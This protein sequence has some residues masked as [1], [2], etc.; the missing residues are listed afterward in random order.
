MTELIK[1]QIA[2]DLVSHHALGGGSYVFKS[3][4]PAYLK[5]LLSDPEQ[6]TELNIVIQPNCS[7]HIGA[8]CSLGLTFVVTRRMLDIG[9]D[10]SITCD[11]WDRANGGQTTIDGVV[12][13]R[14]LRDVGKFQ[15]FLP[16]YVEILRI[17]GDTYHV[18]YRLRLEEEFL[19]NSEIPGV[20][21][22][23]IL[24]R[25]YYAKYL[26]PEKG[27]LAIRSACPQCGLIEKYGTKNMYAED[28]SSVSFECPIHGRFSYNIH[29]QANQLH[30]NCQLFNLV[31]GL[32]YERVPY[33][34]IE[35]CGGDYAGFWQEQL[36]WR[37]LS[38]PIIIVYTPLISD[39]SSC[40]ISKSMY[41]Q[42]AG[43]DY[44]CRAGQ[45]YLLNYDVFR[46]QGKNISVL[47]KEIEIWVD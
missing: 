10:V 42:K 3:N 13:Q 18:N 24:K 16:D 2:Y 17:L 43:Y 28:G 45:E 35:I 20:V 32:F 46:K 4:Y 38:R 8:L 5:T 37:F 7:P 9:L 23:I 31:L 27:F 25:D 29:T 26:A 11:L 40:K 33:N 21:R 22:D 39:W 14:T 34:Y 12:Y 15:R 30:F 44:L 36:M 41:L 6:R 47:W 1:S 19:S